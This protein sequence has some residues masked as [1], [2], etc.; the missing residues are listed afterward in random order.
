[1][2]KQDTTSETTGPAYTSLYTLGGAAALIAAVLT[3]SE[4]V[5]LI[6]YPPPRTVSE[7]FMLFQSNWIIGLLD[8]WGVEVPMY[9]LFTIV[10]LALYVVLRAANKG[11]SAVALTFALLG[12]G[13]FLATNNPFAMLS[14]SNQYAAATTDAERATYLAAGQALLA[15]TNQRVVGRFNM[16][17]FLVSIAGLI[18]SSVMLQSAAFGNGTASVGMLAH[19]LSFADYL[20]QALTTSAMVSLFLILPNALFLV[21]WFALVSRR[22]YQ[23]G[24]LEDSSPSSSGLGLS[25]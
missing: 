24:R 1:M 18:V 11:G 22:L 19:A 25:A 3:V 9:I 15:N 8:F 6:F 14:L 5:G 12:I 16:G 10:F 2:M 23:L 17:L 21:L 7:W 4:V 13:I 20:R